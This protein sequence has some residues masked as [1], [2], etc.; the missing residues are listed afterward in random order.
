MFNHLLK[1][2]LIYAFSYLIR[3]SMPSTCTWLGCKW[4]IFL[5]PRNYI[6]IM[7]TCLENMSQPISFSHIQSCFLK[8]AKIRFLQMHKTYIL[9][10]YIRVNSQP[11]TN[12]VIEGY[13][14]VVL[15]MPFYIGLSYR[16]IY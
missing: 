5:H 14:N 10:L 8:T 3:I 11:L 4:V 2:K 13:T 7:C 1:Y 15:A 16:T 12:V 6:T 9:H